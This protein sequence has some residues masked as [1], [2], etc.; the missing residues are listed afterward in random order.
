MRSQ[1]VL[2]FGVVWFAGLLLF[3]PVLF[4]QETK[5]NFGELK[6][7]LLHA[8]TEEPVFG[9]VVLKNKVFER[10]MNV[11]GDFV[12][13]NLP[14]GVYR[15]AMV[16]PGFKPEEVPVQIIPGETVEIL[17]EAVPQV[18]AVSEVVVA[19]STYS[20]FRQPQNLQ[21]YLDRET[22][23]NTPHFNDDVLR[24]MESLPGTS[25]N[26]FGASFTVRG[27]E[28]REVSVLLDGMELFEPY[29][30]KDFTGVF[31]YFD[32]EILGGLSL[33]TGGYGAKFGNAMSGVLEMETV[34]PSEQRNVASLSFGNLS[35]QSEGT[36]AGGLGS[37]VFS[38]RRGYLDLLLSFAEDDEENEENDITYFDSLGKLAYVLSPN[39]K[40]SLNY[41]LAG[42]SFV[43]MEREDGEIEDT[44]ADY[45]DLYTWVTW[46]GL[47]RDDLESTAVVY[48]GDLSQRRVASSQETQETSV[49][50][51]NRDLE[52]FGGK[53]DWEW[54]IHSG[55]FLRWGGE[56]R[57]VEATYDYDGFYSSAAPIT[58]RAEG[59][60]AVQLNPSGE[61]YSAYLSD[62]FR[63]SEAFIME[64]GLRYDRQSLLDDSQISP[65]LNAT[66]QLGERTNLRF[67]VGDFHQVERPHDL[68]V[69]DGVMAFAEREKATHYLLS[70]ERPFSNHLDFRVEGYFK[71]IQDPRT[72]YENLNQT[73]V[74]Y[75]GG[76]Q[77]RIEIDPESSEIYGLELVFK[78]DFGRNLSWFANY[79][80]SKAEDRIDGRTQPRQRDQEHSFNV[81]MNYRLGKK[82]QFSLAWLYHTGWRVTPI[83]IV[84][85]ENGPALEYG[86]IFSEKLPAYHRLD[87]RINRS[88]FLG[89]KRSF[90][91][92]IDVF[93]AYNRKNIRGYE[94]F[95]IQSDENGMP[96]LAFEQE[97]WL[98]ILP[99]FG[100]SWKF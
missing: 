66:Y 95:S 99:A 29:H 70:Y 24:A 75:P 28:S 94:G 14:A 12:M 41:M 55:H 30:L 72:R 19:P 63:L 42:D 43:E 49:F 88:V 74:R 52:Y 36:F 22:I 92:Y 13:A 58:D 59:Q 20:I 87:F 76:S 35:F 48:R 9:N 57:S 69:A 80:W 37:Y 21:N 67:A 97:E 71:D 61:E 60:V 34:D 44:D 18:V 77:D 2:W 17:I 3:Q 86:E 91:F 83:H 78:Q 68:Q 98:P 8:L 56:I 81:N 27:G 6:G 31:S 93:N 89:N 16:S 90:E 53:W 1:R 51:D 82:W 45:D 15:L 79:A 7:K 85:S 10:S 47:W 23:K 65:R 4:A 84:S 62:R 50:K 5:G 46:Q 26:D 33:S 96:T 54:R 40:L 11:T 32:P 64:L 39:H 73:L 25:S 38:G 100:L